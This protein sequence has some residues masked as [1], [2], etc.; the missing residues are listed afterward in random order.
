M[1]RMCATVEFSFS[2]RIQLQVE[3]V[4]SEHQRPTPDVKPSTN[5]DQNLRRLNSR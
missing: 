1:H 4:L 5:M 3:Y 2:S